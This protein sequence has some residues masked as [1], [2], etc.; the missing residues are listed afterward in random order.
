MRGL[1]R[2]A[3][4]L[5]FLLALTGC[6]GGDGDSSSDPAPAR[7]P[8]PAAAPADTGYAPYVSATT[9]ALTDTAGAPDTYNLAFVLSDGEGCTPMWDGAVAVDDAAIPTRL[10]LLT[11]SGADLRVSFG[12][13]D[14]AELATVCDS[15]AEL[16][17][18]YGAALDA[19]DAKKADFDIEGGALGDAGSVD[20]RN[21]A[22]AL[23][24]KERGD[25]E[26]SYTL[27]VM[28]AGLDEESLDLLAS[29]EER[30]VEVATVNLM[31]MNYGE[32]FDGD[33]GAYAVTAA[34]AAH[35]QL[36]EVFGRTEAQAW[37]GLAL[38]AMIGVNDVQGETFTPQDAAQV[39]EFAESK[40]VGWVSMWATHRDRACQ[41]G[42]SEE[43]SGVDQE[44]GA[45][46]EALG[47]SPR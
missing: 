47:G 13:A 45:F 27:P 34:G 21:E 36:M 7:K 39:R 37:E 28:P 23:L 33:M 14:G 43:C 2:P 3:A 16:A 32:E 29:A 8:S 26:V 1:L 42:Q 12:G 30:G 18:A 17:R 15:A 6:S 46:G 9:P 41:E 20:L 4:G 25:L 5:G 11:G 38:T 35:G 22:I 10:A 24:Q 19:A 44:D 40:G 31:A